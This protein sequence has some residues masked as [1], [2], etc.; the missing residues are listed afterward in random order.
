MT[1]TIETTLEWAPLWAAMKAAP[2]AWIPT[3]EDMF[4]EMLECV[5]PRA[6]DRDRFLVGEAER[7]NEQGQPVYACFKQVGDKFFARYMTLE[8]YRHRV[9]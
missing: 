9:E 8:Q 4:W 7:D 3:T 5:P 2:D 1:T 6:Q